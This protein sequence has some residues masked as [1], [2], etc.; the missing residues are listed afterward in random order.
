MSCWTG[1]QTA[2]GQAEGRKTTRP[3]GA[4]E[5]F[6]KKAVQKVEDGGDMEDEGA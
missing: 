2:T 5:M 3:Q 1:I 4:Q 6:G